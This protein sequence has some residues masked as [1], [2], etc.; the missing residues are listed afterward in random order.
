MPVLPWAEARR[1]Y[2][3]ARLGDSYVHETPWVRCITRG[4]PAGMFP[5]GYKNAYQII[6]IPGYVVIAYEMIHETRIIPVD[7]RPHLGHEV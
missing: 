6:Q 2:D 4:M 3:L 7:G 1:D 5:A